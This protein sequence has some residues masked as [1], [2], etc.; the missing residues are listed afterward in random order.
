MLGAAVL[1]MYASIGMRFR[2]PEVKK[3]Y[4]CACCD[5][6]QAFI[7]SEELMNKEMIKILSKGPNDFNGRIPEKN[8][9]RGEVHSMD[10]F[11]LRMDYVNFS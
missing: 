5:M 7:E 10:G 4:H 9:S 8:L 6:N 3:K 11:S 1:G 2:P